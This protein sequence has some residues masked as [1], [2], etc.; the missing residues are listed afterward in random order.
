MIADQ[1]HRVSPPPHIVPARPPRPVR[2]RQA[3]AGK[4]QHHTTHVHVPALSPRVSG[5]LADTHR[6]SGTLISRRKDF[7]MKTLARSCRADRGHGLSERWR[8]A[9]AATRKRSSPTT[10]IP[11]L[12]NATGRTSL[13]PQRHLQH[14]PL[15]RSAIRTP[16]PMRRRR[17]SCRRIRTIRRRSR[18][19]AR[20]P[21]CQNKCP[22][23]RRRLRRPSLLRLRAAKTPTP[24]A[25]TQYKAG[26]PLWGPPAEASLDQ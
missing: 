8:W 6:W 23:A 19:A 16:G 9:P 25:Q 1:V 24:S 11:S 21:R 22:P 3:A 26:G 13:S 20:R 18:Q 12:Q 2:L 10:P 15:A 17:R 14:P 5:T 7:A 4:W